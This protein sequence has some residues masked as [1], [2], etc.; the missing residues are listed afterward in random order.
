MAVQPTDQY[1]VSRSGTN[2]KVPAADLS[3]KLQPTDFMLVERSGT[4]YKVSGADVTSQLGGGNNE[5]PHAKGGVVTQNNYYVFHTF[6]ESGT[7]E[8][9][10]ALSAGVLKYFRYVGGGAG[11][12]GQTGG[13]GGGGRAF[14][15]SAGPVAIPAG[16]TFT[17]TIGAG[18]AGGPGGS[19]GQ[20]GGSTTITSPSWPTGPVSFPF[21]AGGGGGGGGGSSAGRTGTAPPVNPPAPRRG[22]GGGG[23]G[24]VSGPP[25]PSGGIAQ[26][27]TE[28]SGGGGRNL[29]GGGGGGT[30]NVGG[31]APP[32]AQAGNNGSPTSTAP[33][34]RAGPGGLGNSDYAQAE[35]YAPGGFPF[36][37]SSRVSLTLG[38]GGGGGRNGPYIGLSPQNQAPFSAPGPSPN[39]SIQV[40]QSGHGKGPNSGSPSTV[41]AP[42]NG[43]IGS[44]GGGGG[45]GQAGPGQQGGNGGSG[46]VIFFYKRGAPRSPDSLQ[47]G[48][49]T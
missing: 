11:G 9:Q 42:F 31:V 45:G 22:A 33:F 36:P 8:I 21:G 18:G 32:S 35:D 28:K 1:L 15:T 19:S 12:G 7:L 17:I 24:N 14:Q 27:P 34:H 30:K 48:N 26:H 43:D 2:Y 16:T 40:P 20:D 37:G 47:E 38:G 44:G 6:N 3:S 39:S 29:S 25:Y 5:S 10:A 13:G 23:G 49:L 41:D 46:T 4:H